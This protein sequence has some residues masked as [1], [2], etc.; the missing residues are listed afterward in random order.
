MIK[1][2]SIRASIGKQFNT[3]IEIQDKNIYLSYIGLILCVFLYLLVGI[4]YYAT[5]YNNV[6]D[7]YD[8]AIAP[9]TWFLALYF[10]VTTMTT[11]GYGYY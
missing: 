9:R 10:V 11:L 1:R 4:C 6:D 8:G 7:D 2:D 3:L 5:T